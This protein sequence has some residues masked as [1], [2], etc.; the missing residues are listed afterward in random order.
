[1]RFHI[2]WLFMCLVVI[3]CLVVPQPA[4]TKEDDEALKSEAPLPIDV[5]KLGFAHQVDIVVETKRDPR[6]LEMKITQENEII[7]IDLIVNRDQDHEQVK[8]IAFDVVMRV[9]MRSLDDRPKSGKEPGKGL[10]TY[11]VTITRPDA[12]VLLTATK[13]RRKRKMIYEDAIL[14]TEPLTRADVNAR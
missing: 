5:P 13:P 11:K 1:M 14:R 10:Y 3:S 7:H 6:V 4:H 2:S 8:K 9:K 12:V